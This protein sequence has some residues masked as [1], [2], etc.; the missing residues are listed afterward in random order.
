MRLEFFFEIGA[1]RSPRSILAL[2][3]IADPAI[4]FGEKTRRNEDAGARGQ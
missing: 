2:G 1:Q 4:E 3:L